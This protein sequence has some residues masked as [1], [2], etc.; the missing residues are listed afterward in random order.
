MFLQNYGKRKIIYGKD[1]KKD[2]ILP[3][4]SIEITKENS[5]DLKKINKMLPSETRV[6]EGD[7]K[8]K[9]FPKFDEEP[10]EKEKSKEKA[11]AEKDK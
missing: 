7:G 1:A 2:F 9:E 4:A 8:G 10:K 5:V 11:G 6:T 3:G